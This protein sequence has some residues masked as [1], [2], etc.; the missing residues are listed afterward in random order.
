MSDFRQW[1][2]SKE[3]E[4]TQEKEH[5][6]EELY[7]LVA[8]LEHSITHLASQIR[9]VSFLT[10]VIYTCTVRSVGALSYLER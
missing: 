9:D 3:L 10:L 5:Y 6:V 7:S 8:A 1:W 4:L 2:A